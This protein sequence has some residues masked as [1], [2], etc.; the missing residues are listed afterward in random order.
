[1]LDKRH[2]YFLR[3]PN[4]LLSKNRRQIN[5][6]S[7]EKIRSWK[8]IIG[9]FNNIDKKKLLFLILTSKKLKP[10]VGNINMAMIGVDI[11]C[12]TYHL[13]ITLVFAI[14]IGDIQYQIEKDDKTEII[15]K[16]IISQKYHTFLDIC[17]K[18]DSD[19]LFS[20]QKYDYKIY[21]EEKYK[22]AYVL[23]YKIL[24]KK[25]DVVK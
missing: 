23:L 12:A 13:K 10:K 25:I 20:Y 19:T 4:K 1:M 5:K 21:P 11:Y 2:S 8:A 22:H 9:I 6:A 16:N 14:L 24:F 17:S 3:M 15:P 7:I 18:K